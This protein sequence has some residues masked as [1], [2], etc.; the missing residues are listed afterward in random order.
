MDINSIQQ[1]GMWVWSQVRDCHSND[2]QNY[3]K[4]AFASAV[5]FCP[6]LSPDYSFC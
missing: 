6:N 2:G 1:K 3:K 4:K 5:N